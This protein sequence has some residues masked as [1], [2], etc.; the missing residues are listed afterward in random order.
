LSGDP[1]QDYFIDGVVGDIIN[2]LSR[3]RAFS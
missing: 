1:S 3:V 2:G